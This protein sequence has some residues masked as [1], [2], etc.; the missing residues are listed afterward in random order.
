MMYDNNIIQNKDLQEGSRI[1]L[2]NARKLS[3]A[4]NC[5]YDA[6]L[7][8]SGIVLG[9][10]ALEEIGKSHYLFKNYMDDNTV[11]KSDK[12][13]CNHNSKLNALIDYYKN[14]DNNN[15]VKQLKDDLI[16]YKTIRFQL[17]YA[18][19]STNKKQ[20]C[21]LTVN[22]FMISYVKHIVQVL[23]TDFITYL[24][25]DADLTTAHHSDILKLL[26]EQQI[27]LK[28]QQCGVIIKKTNEIIS[29]CKCDKKWWGAYWVKN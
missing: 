3:N 5:L 2:D 22:K 9:T 29:G 28:C 16:L 25:G 8:E 15:A 14:N 24:G 13:F 7:Y 23:I 12:I 21:K 11:K 1:A 4:M 18:D 26:D 27:F 10:L 6:N 17:L 20:W 19:W